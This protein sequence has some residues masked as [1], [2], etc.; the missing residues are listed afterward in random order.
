[1]RLL[2]DTH[3]FLWW[4]EGNAKLSK[5]ASSLIAD[6]ANILLLSVVSAW[7]LIVKYQ[8]K[9][10]ELPEPPSIYVPTRT[11][12][13]GIEIL[14]VT[15]A[16][17]LAAESFPLHHRDPFDRLIIAQAKAEN[18]PIVTLDRHFRDYPVK[19]LW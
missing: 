16:H 1:M 11:A 18:I 19:V 14:P 5:K 4:N 3:T 7:E 8:S 9:K 17:T 6:P 15:L 10:L 13:Y 12:H 2:L